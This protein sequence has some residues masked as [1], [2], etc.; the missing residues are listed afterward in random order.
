MGDNSKIEWCDATWTPIRAVRLDVLSTGEPKERIGWHCEHVSEG[1]R[2]C[3]AEGMNRRLGTGL[4][5]KPGNL[6]G[7]RDLRDYH[8]PFADVFLD[9]RMLT[10][11]LRWKKPRKIFVCSM[12]DLFADFVRDEWID[13]MF[14]VMAL[15]PQHTF[16]IATKRPERMRENRQ[17]NNRSNAKDRLGEIVRYGR[18]FFKKAEFD[19]MWIKG[20]TWPLSNVWLGVSIEDQATADARIP[21]LLDTPAAIRW[22]SAEPLLGPVDLTVVPRAPTETD[23]HL[24]GVERVRAFWTDPLSGTLGVYTQDGAVLETDFEIGNK[25]DWVVMGGE[26]GPGAR[27][28]DIDDSE[29]VIAQCRAAGVAAYL[30]QLGARPRIAGVAL[31]LRDRKGGDWNEWPDYLRIREFPT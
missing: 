28:F 29:S 14:A 5:F 8:A 27:D 22:V 2:N 31:P 10:Q 3:Y 20:F 30:K 23:H 16:I 7:R 24:I 19:A 17:R 21:I 15:C 18:Q 12:T 11:P 6:R 13:K 9:E 1:C 26:S 4:K 25:L